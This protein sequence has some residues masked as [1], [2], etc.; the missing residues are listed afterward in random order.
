MEYVENKEVE[1]EQTRGIFQDMAKY[2]PSKIVGMIGN[3]LIVPVYT[4]ILPPEQYGLFVFRLG[5]AFRL[6]IFQT[7]PAYAGHAEISY[8]AGFYVDF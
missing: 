8:D 5:G 4:S 1:E 2:A 6:K 7:P 3:A